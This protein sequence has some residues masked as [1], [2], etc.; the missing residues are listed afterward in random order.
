MAD[1]HLLCP[2]DWRRGTL[3]P[4]PDSGLIVR[5]DSG[6]TPSTSRADYWD[7]DVPWLTPREVTRMTEG[8]FVSRTER[9]LTRRGLRSSAARLLPPGT[10]M[11]TKRAPVGAVAVNAIEMATN[12]G[13][14]NFRCGERLR[15]LYLAWWL[16][17]NRAYLEQVAN[18]S[19]YPE[20]YIADLFELEL[21]APPVPVQDRILEVLSALDLAAAFSAAAARVAV[22]PD[23]VPVLQEQGRRLE[24]FRD[25]ILPLLLSGEIDASRLEPPLPPRPRAHGD[26]QGGASAIGAA[27]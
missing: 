14:L 8:M 24:R 7:G 11:L 18:G 17:A 5:V 3:E 10:V 27:G 22:S 21:A 1:P 6:G 4:D 25:H 20:L 19:T 9:T 2:R 23:R 15:P 26:H 12:Q 16:R 13:F